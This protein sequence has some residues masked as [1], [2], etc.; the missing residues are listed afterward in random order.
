MGGGEGV[1][2]SP[3]RDKDRRRRGSTERRLQSPNQ[4]IPPLIREH[5]TEP[6]RASPLQPDYPGC[7]IRVHRSISNVLADRFEFRLAPIA[8]KAKQTHTRKDAQ[9]DTKERDGD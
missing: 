9:A 8:R 1:P 4:E 6:H 3:P 5:G 7:P 2:V